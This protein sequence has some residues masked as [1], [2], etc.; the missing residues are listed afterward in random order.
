MSAGLGGIKMPFIHLLPKHFL[1]TGFQ[2]VKLPIPKQILL[3]ENSPPRQA[4]KG[5]GS[6]IVEKVAKNFFISSTPHFLC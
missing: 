2:P 1:Q 4:G 5:T 6:A 3:V